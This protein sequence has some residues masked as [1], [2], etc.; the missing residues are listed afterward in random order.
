ML[1]FMVDILLAAWAG[2]VAGLTDE[3]DDED[4][5]GLVASRV[6]FWESLAT[7][8]RPEAREPQRSHVEGRSLPV[9]GMTSEAP[10]VDAAVPASTARQIQKYHE[11]IEAVRAQAVELEKRVEGLKQQVAQKHDASEQLRQ[12]AAFIKQCMLVQ[13]ELCRE[14]SQLGQRLQYLEK[15]NLLLSQQI[16]EIYA[17]SAVELKDPTIIEVRDTALEAVKESEA[18]SKHAGQN[19]LCCTAEAN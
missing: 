2:F 18:D 13:R 11:E 1:L 19:P 7:R 6:D 4:E 14:Q 16:K 5:K 10:S 17:P 12:Q 15:A 9:Q 3:E 8:N